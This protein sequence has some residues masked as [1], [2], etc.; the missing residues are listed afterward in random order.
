LTRPDVN[1]AVVDL[2]PASKTAAKKFLEESRKNP[3]LI[4]ECL[5]RA[6]PRPLSPHY[7]E[8]SDIENAM[9]QEIL[10]GG[11]V[12]E[13]AKKASAAIDQLSGS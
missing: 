12:M 3:D 4:F 5:Q 11:N 1:G 13:A 8:V 9:I 2:I 7:L 6:K 10:G